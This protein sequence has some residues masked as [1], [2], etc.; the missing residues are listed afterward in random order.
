MGIAT[1]GRHLR[2]YGELMRLLVKYGRGDLAKEMKDAGLGGGLGDLTMGDAD[3]G[4]REVPTEA[5]EL[6]SDL[7]ALGPTFIKLGQLLSTRTDLLPPAYTEA[8][9][10][11]CRTTWSRSPSSE[12][13]EVFCGELGIDTA[14]PPSTGSTPSRWRR[15][16]WARS[17]G[18]SSATAGRG[19]EGPAPRH[20]GADQRRHGGPGRAGRVARPAHRHRPA[21]RVRRAARAV[22]PLA[23]GR[24]RLPAGGR[25]PPPPRRHRRALRPRSWSRSR[26]TTSRPAGC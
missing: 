9:S 11:G 18:P 8:L 10:A 17:T 5:L 13:D 3:A 25:Q 23:P 4:T 7:E 20:P 2:L 22:R 21:L 24:A 14:R 16:R 19:R 12:V 6:A 1:K 15:R 26:S